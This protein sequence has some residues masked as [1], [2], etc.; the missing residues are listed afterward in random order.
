MRLISICDYSKLDIREAAVPRSSPATPS[1]RST[2][3][4]WLHNW[5]RAKLG[6]SFD[7]ADLAQDTFIRV[8]RH[9]LKRARNL[10][11][12]KFER[13]ELKRL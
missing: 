9:R 10:S 6:N 3:H 12:T 4:G 13:Y 8:L 2:H 1:T 11:A 5:L 7:A